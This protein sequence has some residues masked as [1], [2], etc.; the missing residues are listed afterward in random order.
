[1][2]DLKVFTADFK[3]FADDVDANKKV[4]INSILNFLQNTAWSH[5]NEFEKRYGTILPEKNMWAIIKIRLKMH[6]IPEWEDNIKVKTWATGIERLFTYRNFEIL[7]EKNN[8]IGISTFKWVILDVLKKRPVKPDVF[9]NRFHFNET[10]KFFEM[11]RKINPV[12][13]PEFISCKKVGYTDID[14]NKHVNSVKYIEWV[15]DAVNY[16]LIKDKKFN[17][18]EIDFLSE[19]FAGEEIKISVENARKNPLELI[20]ELNK[21][22][23]NEIVC[24]A[25]MVFEL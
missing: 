7:D 25:Q 17:E 22:K 4:K 21:E 19:T 5:Y 14:V 23:S 12:S 13:Q 6:K 10:E 2:D 1:M 15:L 18:L 24:R 16:D 3:I 8:V 11:E 9:L 20:G